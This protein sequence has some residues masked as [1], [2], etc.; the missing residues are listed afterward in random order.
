M[1]KIEFVSYTG[2]YP[3]LCSGVLTVLID[4]KE[5]KFGHEPCSGY[6]DHK[7]HEFKYEDSNYQKF[8]CSG[9]HLNKDYEA[10]KG[11]WERDPWYSSE[12]PAELRELLPELLRVFN[13]NV[14]Y[15]CCGGCA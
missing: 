2:R 5:Y 1:A 9:G 7:T 6:Y 13:I 12:L 11:P 8:W 3:T 10:V 4:G 15:G 14:A